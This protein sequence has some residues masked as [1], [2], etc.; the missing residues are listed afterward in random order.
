MTPSFGQTVLGEMCPACY[1]AA[2]AV[3][4]GPC[5]LA[6]SF[7]KGRGNVSVAELPRQD[8]GGQCTTV[9]VTSLRA[10]SPEAARLLDERYRVAL[11]RFCWG[12][13]G[14]VEE[15]E[16]AVQEIFLNVVGAE[17]VPDSFRP[18]L[19]KVARNH[20]LN[21]V[22]DRGGRKGD[23]TLA[24]ASQVYTALTG[25][26]TRLAR[27]EE[28]LRLVELVQA[29]AEEHREVL[30]LRYVEDLSR[31]EIAEVLELPESVVKSRLFEGMR[32]LR[33]HA[34]GLLDT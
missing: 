10:K 1:A 30:R 4:D 5:D 15:A 28:R 18:W 6:S 29:L 34:S 26:L 12:Y 21:R 8:G 22:R 17:V 31:S 32:K 14:S 13:V 2:G 24:D 16:D 3:A 25:H 23:R 11:V 27:D 19:Y 9:L 33:E 7:L 20:C